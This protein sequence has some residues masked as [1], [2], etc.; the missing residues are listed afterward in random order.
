VQTAARIS[1][2]VVLLLAT[3]CGGSCAPTEQ[4]L[5]FVRG[6]TPANATLWIADV[7]GRHARRL[8]PGYGGVVSPDGRTIAVGRDDGIHL[9]STDGK[10]ERRLTAN[11]FVPHAW[12]RDGKWIVATTANVLAV[13]DVDSGRSRVVARG[14]QYGISPSPDGRRLVYARAARQTRQGICG[15][16]IN[17]YVVALGGGAPSRLTRDGRSAFPVW[18]KDRIAFARLPKRLRF[19]D[20][21]AP[22]IWTMRPDG[23]DLRPILARAPGAIAHFGYYGLQPVAWLEHG[24]LIVGVRSEWGNEAATLDADTRRLRRLGSY[25]DESSRDGRFVLG[26]GGNVKTTISITRVRDG[27]RVFVLRGNVCCPDWNR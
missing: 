2:G 5:V 15:D 21:F 14:P 22:G 7:D 10:H 19:E 6:T 25:I 24:D 11:V 20:C 3:G 17:L 26:S 16:R 12:S 13:I 1:V 4:H 27:R 9:V 8:T 18:G 23:S